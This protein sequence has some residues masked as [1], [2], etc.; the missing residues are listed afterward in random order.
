MEI[1]E[2]LRSYDG[3][4]VA[5]FRAVADVV[6][7]APE[8]AVPQL[9]ALAASDETALQVG[10]T[11][12][13]KHLAEGGDAPRGE[14]AAQAIDLLE[15]VHEPDAVLHLLQTLP[16]LEIPADRRVPLRCALKRLIRSR[17]V[18]VR[19]WAYN[20]LG[21]L[22]AADPGLRGEVEVLFEAAEATEPASVRVRIRRARAGLGSAG[23]EE[24]PASPAP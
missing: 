7:D 24:S 1:A 21:L 6:R 5:P 10:A 23:G 17:H 11:W 14:V 16:H 8:S 22:A 18:F 20:G 2:T 12:V 15:R 9:L 3:K 4:R 19:A 13:V